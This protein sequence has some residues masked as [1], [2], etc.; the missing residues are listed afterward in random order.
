ML[1][2]EHLLSAVEAA[3]RRAGI[4]GTGRTLLVAL[5]GG[6]DSVA[7]LRTVHTLGSLHGFTVR[8][9]HVEHGLRGE[10]SLEDA[11]F[12]ERLCAELSV[13]FTC[14]KANLAGN[15]ASPGVEERAREARHTLLLRRAR[16]CHAD[17]LLFAHH[18]DDQAETVLSH[19]LRGSGA[20]GLSGM[21][22]STQV[23]GVLVVRPFLTVSHV[24][25][26]AAFAADG[27][28]Y[29]TDESNALPCCQRNRLRLA[30][31]PLLMQENP[32]AAEHMAQSALLLGMDDAYLSQQ[33]DA[34]LR[35]ALLDRQPFYCLRKAPLLAA[36]GAIVLRVLRRFARSGAER[37]AASNAQPAPEEETIS[38]A[39]SLRLIALLAAPDGTTLNLPFG[40]QALVTARYVHLLRMAGGAPLTPVSTA[41]AI[42]GLDGHKSVRFGAWT[43]HITPYIPAKSPPPDGKRTIVLPCRMLAAI[44]LRTALPGDTIRPFG[45]TGNK[46]LR[47]YFTDRKLDAPFRPHVPLF[48]LGGEV[49]WVVGMGAAE[50]TR[51]TDEPSVLIAASGALPWL[52][53]TQGKR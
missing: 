15:M 16:E 50:A 51:L 25:I 5:S 42:T 3:L 47:R 52:A 35:K 27:I 7:L 14:D 40:L 28:P 2:N 6:A 17:A 11:R 8:A 33:A 18:R 20:R 30:V 46:P 19:L 4:L 36:P 31:F 10:A 26:M 44:T 32:R 23:D 45:A 41:E 29:R 22:E 1:M 53:P 38:A 43:F 13:P 39:D 12:C 49:L 9:A 37:L 24:E 21:R 48:C 34:L